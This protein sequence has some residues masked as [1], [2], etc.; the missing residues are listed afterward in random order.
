MSENAF[1]IFRN[2]KF[3]AQIIMY[4]LHFFFFKLCVK[5][6]N[7]IKSGVFLI[8]GI[9]LKAKLYIWLGKKA[10]P[11]LCSGLSVTIN[12]L[13]KQLAIGPSKCA[14]LLYSS[15]FSLHWWHFLMDSMENKLLMS[16]IFWDMGTT[17]EKL[18]C[19]FERKNVPYTAL[20]ST[21]HLIH[22]WLI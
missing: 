10:R 17:L 2:V 13:G 9:P 8:C 12:I 19:A 11:V 3:L 5:T 1:G 22:L 18:I 14:M 7:N 20:T 6:Y 4:S 16:C 15:F 21:G